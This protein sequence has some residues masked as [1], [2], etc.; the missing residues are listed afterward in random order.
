MLQLQLSTW[1]A[2]FGRL[3]III[4]IIIITT[5]TIIII[6]EVYEG[7]ILKSYKHRH[8][9]SPRSKYPCLLYVCVC[10]CGV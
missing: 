9:L 4:I 2:E 10:V 7:H 1:Y 5:T 8:A 3:I 6:W